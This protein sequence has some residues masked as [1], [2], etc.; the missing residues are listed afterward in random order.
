MASPNSRVPALTGSP[1]IGSALTDTLDDLIMTRKI[2]PQ[3]AMKII[4]NFD[5]A[6][7]DTLAEKVKSRMSFKGHL[8]TYRF[9]DEVWTFVLKDITVKLDNS[10]TVHADKIKIVSCN[11][12]K[13]GDELLWRGPPSPPEQ[14]RRG[15]RALRAVR[16]EV[17]P[18]VRSGVSSK[19]KQQITPE[20]TPSVESGI[21]SETT[22]EV[23]L[24]VKPETKKEFARDSLDGYFGE[25][26][27]YLDPN[28]PMQ[29]DRLREADFLTLFRGA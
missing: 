8:D 24:K 5:K 25:D 9:C 16:K 1:S 22:P 18:E 12:K 13:P 17:K 20:A 7:A 23:K 21:E 11:S 27:G 6:V 3:L 19:V 10:N 29:D 26:E 28:R 15:P 14:R 2:E 4:T